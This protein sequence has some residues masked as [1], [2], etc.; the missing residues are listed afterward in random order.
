MV[1]K[2]GTVQ[3]VRYIKEG[4]LWKVT[5]TQ[6]DC[7]IPLTNQKL[8]T[9]VGLECRFLLAHQDWHSLFAHKVHWKSLVWSNSKATSVLKCQTHTE[10][11]FLVNDEYHSLQKLK[12][13][14]EIS[15]NQEY[16]LWKWNFSWM[17]LKL[18]KNISHHLRAHLH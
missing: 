12:L 17:D 10:Y 6:T 2:H 14:M 7:M 8:C 15:A 18:T 9:I 3:A 11:S 4:A 1:P 5:Y 13:L 16:P